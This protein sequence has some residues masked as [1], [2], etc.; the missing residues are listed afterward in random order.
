[1]E[2]LCQESEQAVSWPRVCS[3]LPQEIHRLFRNAV[4][5][6]P[7]FVDDSLLGRPRLAVKLNR[8]RGVRL[9]PPPGRGASILSINVYQCAIHATRQ[10]YDQVISNPIKRL[11]TIHPNAI[12][13]RRTVDE[14]AEYVRQG[15]RTELGPDGIPV[16][17]ASHPPLRVFRRAP[18][19]PST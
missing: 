6:A 1:M 16:S 14:S 18:P 13:R 7:R 17:E 12:E 5:L 2:K 15:G 9:L 19:T 10:P 4:I 11:P 8:S 3:S